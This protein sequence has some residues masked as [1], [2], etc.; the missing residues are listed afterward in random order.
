[1]E[2]NI[3]HLYPD[4][5]N[6]YGDRGNVITLVERCTRR[7]ITLRVTDTPLGERVDLSRQDILFIGGGQDAE[8]GVLLDELRATR[9]AEIRAAIEDGKVV[10]AICGGY[11]LLGHSYKTWDG[12]EMDFIGAL[13][14][15]S[16]GGRERMTGDYMFVWD[17]LE[18]PVQIVGFENHSAKTFLGSGV[19][20]FGKV[21]AGSGNNGEDG[22]EGARY[23]NVF[24]TYSHG[25]L[26]PKNPKLA[27]HLLSLALERK[28]G[29]AELAP[30]DDTLEERAHQFMVA[31]LSRT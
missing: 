5:L 20:P 16:V 29:I 31:R 4:L 7:G 17:E 8:Q 22:T 19:K 12:K 28:Y 21:L 10:L 14:L 30:L 13:D 2:L 23:L 3:C 9:G 25:P 6:L 26:L 15:H 18:E 1:M 27:D 24:G 11:Q